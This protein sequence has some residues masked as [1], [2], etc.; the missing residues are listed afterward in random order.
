[1]ELTATTLAYLRDEAYAFLAREALAAKLDEVGRERATVA[2]TRPPFGGML[3]RRETREAF[4]RSMRV[5]DDNEAVLRAQLAHLTGIA[6]WLRPIIRRDVSA[7]LASVSPDYCRLLQISARVDDWERAYHAVPELLVALARDARGVRQALAGGEK[8][9]VR[10]LAILRD[11]AARLASQLREL[12]LV[13][14]A[15]QALAPADLAAQVRFPA[16]PDLQWVTWVGRLAV[17]PPPQALAEVTRAETEVREFLAGP[18]EHLQPR[19]AAVRA[20]CAQRAD[21]M[22]DRYWET[23]RQHARAHYVEECD[24]DQVIAMLHERYVDADLRR[25]QEAM[26]VDPFV[27]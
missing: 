22:L 16:V 21:T 13:E 9:I 12:H 5:V 18:G 19:L 23:L 3:A 26:T 4:A 27:R 11:S 7:Y 17:L 10:E 6:E 1:M 15:A 2:S 14:Q 24:I 8:T 25:R 20:A